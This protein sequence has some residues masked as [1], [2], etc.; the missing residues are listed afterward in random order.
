VEA[1]QIYLDN[2]GRI[3]AD[4]TGGGGNIN[5]RSPLIVLRHGSNISTNAT[6]NNIP[7]GNIEIDS[8]FLVAGKSEDSNISAN[9]V[10]FRGGNVSINAYSMFGIQPRFQP[11]SLSDITATGANFGLN[12][13]INVT[14]AGIDPAAGLVEL[15]TE[16]VDPSRLIATG[17]PANEGNSFI[18]TGRGG[19][20][21]T[22]EQELDDD[23]EWEDRRRLTVR[24]HSP[25]QLTPHSRNI[26][27]PNRSQ[28]LTA[29]PKSYTPI[30]EATGWQ[31]TPSGEII[32]V[33]TTPELGVQHPLNLAVNC[34]GR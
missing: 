14:T 7:G 2:Q 8:R 3:R 33:A 18:I 13:T 23:A 12:G 15:P 32:L 19:L 26:D 16:F 6:G 29:F 21:P 9:S 31:R 24:K 34:Q 20:P 4:T 17:C 25:Q 22:P 11:T 1:N 30:I 28:E 27:T 10:D 5:L